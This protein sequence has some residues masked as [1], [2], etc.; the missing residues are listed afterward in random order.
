M[1]AN[2]KYVDISPGHHATVPEEVALK[3]PHH[4]RPE[5]LEDGEMK[6]VDEKFWEDTAPAPT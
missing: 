1:A 2:C 6:S 5:Y 3:T 4:P